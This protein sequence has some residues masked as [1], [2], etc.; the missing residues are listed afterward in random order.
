MISINRR[1]AS[2]RDKAK[3]QGLE[4]SLTKEDFVEI[5]TSNCKYCGKTE[6]NNLVGVDRFDNKIGYTKDNS[7]PCCQWCN[8]S[9]RERTVE[10]F[11]NWANELVGFQKGLK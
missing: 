10:E 6:I 2:Y 11:L 9:K 5:L 7:V 1:W 4:W 8:Y 3:I